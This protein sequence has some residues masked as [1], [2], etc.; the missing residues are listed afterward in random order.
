MQRASGKRKVVFAQS[1]FLVYYSE[2][3]PA[4]V[5]YEIFP[6]RDLKYLWDIFLKIFNFDIIVDSHEV[7][8][9]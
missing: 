2:I 9:K 7:V 6:L 1:R 5:P 8:K 4:T 3:K